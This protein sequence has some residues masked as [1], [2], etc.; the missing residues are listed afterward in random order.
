MF[1]TLKRMLGGDKKAEPAAEKP[2]REIRFPFEH[3]IVHG[4]EALAR[5]E[6]LEARPGITP[7]IMGPSGDLG[8]I[9]DVVNDEPTPVAEIL[10]EAR[11]VDIASWMAA[12]EREQPD[13]YRVSA[14]SWP[15]DPRVAV[16]AIT[17][18]LDSATKQP[19]REVVIGLVPTANAWEAPAHLDYGGWNDCPRPEVHVALHRRW[20]DGYGA[21]IVCMSDDIVQCTVERPPATRE[22]AMRLAREHFHYCPDLVHQGGE[23]LEYLAAM[24]MKNRVWSFWWD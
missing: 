23:C 19:A 15:E 3:V 4:S 16:T 24:L 1:D 6:E 14:A 22:A 20:R 2:P 9:L 18:H 7:I 5:R 17:V 13:Y 8:L 11:G 21:A 12:N 10:E